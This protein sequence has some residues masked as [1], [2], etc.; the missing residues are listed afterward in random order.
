MLNLRDGPNPIQVKLEDTL[1]I[2]FNF[3]DFDHQQVGCTVISTTWF[4][5]KRHYN[6]KHFVARNLTRK[7]PTRGP[8]SNQ[9]RSKTYLHDYRRMY[10]I[11][12]LMSLEF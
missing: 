4:K 6:F 7:D 8:N 9:G 11:H 3:N 5:T 1:G 2:E 12:K 10:N